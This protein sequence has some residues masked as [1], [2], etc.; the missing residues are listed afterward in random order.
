MTTTEESQSLR[1]ADMQAIGKSAL[2]FAL[3]ALLAICAPAAVYLDIGVFKQPVNEWS[4]T[5][6]IQHIFVLA[7]A[8]LF[9]VKAIRMPRL[10]SFAILAAGLFGCMFLRE[11]DAFMDAIQHGFWV[12]PTSVLAVVAIGLGFSKGPGAVAS[13]MAQ[14]TRDRSYYP[15]LLGLITLL[16]FSRTFGS[17]RAL[18][19]F[20]LDGETVELFKPV[21]Q[22]GLELF[23]YGF[24]L[25]GACLFGR[26]QT[27][28]A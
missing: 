20:L 6:L 10:R 2:E 12:Y 21:L 8:I 19:D 26:T 15:I 28:E 3:L 25:Y 9:A 22:E 5:E 24:L 7:T 23:G 1:L 18:W 16:I 13:G 27:K 11:L 4:V 17:G 14:F